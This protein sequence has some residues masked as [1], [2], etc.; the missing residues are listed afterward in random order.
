MSHV[1]GEA[2]LL[3]RLAPRH[4]LLFTRRAQAC[5]EPTTELVLLNGQWCLRSLQESESIF[6][7]I[8]RGKEKSR[9]LIAHLYIF[10]KSKVIFLYFFLRG[11]ASCNPETD[12]DIT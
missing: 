10:I 11:S 12:P 9:Q 1:E 8:R 7:P 2:R 4:R 6:E 3:E 5:V